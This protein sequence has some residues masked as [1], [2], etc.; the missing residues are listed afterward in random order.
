[1]TSMTIYIDWF[2]LEKSLDNLLDTILVY[3][4]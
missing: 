2:D 1:M 3:L 4:Y